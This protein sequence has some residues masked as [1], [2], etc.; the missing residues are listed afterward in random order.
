MLKKYIS[1][2]QTALLVG[3]L[4]SCSPSMID[5]FSFPTD[6]LLAVAKIRGISAE[7]FGEEIRRQIPAKKDGEERAD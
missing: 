1:V 7:S 3:A 4:T 2:A 5:R 6:L